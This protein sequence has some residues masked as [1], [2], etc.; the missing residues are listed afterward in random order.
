MAAVLLGLVGIAVQ[1]RAQQRVLG[2]DI[3][4]W[5]CG[6]STNGISQ[7]NWNTAYTTGNRQFVF[8]RATRGGTTGVDQPQGTPGG[9]TTATLSHRYDDPR[10]VQNVNRATSAGMVIGPY[11]FA[12]PD[13]AGNTGT[14]EADH[15]IQM[16]GA[17]MRPGYLMPMFDQEAGSGSDTVAQFAIDFSDRIYAVMQIRPCIYINGNYSSIFQGATQAR[18]D[19]IAKP[20]TY[21]PSVLGPDYPMLWDA[22]YPTNYNE[23]VDNPKDT[24]AGFYGPWDDYGDPNPWSFWQYSSTVSM[25]GF[26]G[27]DST[28]DADVSHGDLEYVRNYLVPA[29]WWND[30][31]GDWGTLANWNSGQTPVAPVTPA[32]QAPPYATEPI[33]TARLPGASGSGPT[34]GQYDTVILERPS[35]NIT[36][37]LS[38]GAYNI[39]KL[40]MRESLNLTGGSLT[41]NYDPTYRPDDST[42]VLH[43]GPISAQFSG[44]VTLS[45]GASFTVHTLQV[46]TTRVFTLAGGTLT[47]NTV[48]L[49]PHASTPAKILM[50]GDAAFNGLAGAT[51][52]ITKGAGSGSS[53]FIDLYGGTRGFNVGDGAN[54]VDLS[55]DVPVTNGGL[56]KTGAG[57]MRVISANTYAGGTTVSAGRLLVNNST[58]SGTGTGGVTVS[59]GTLGGTGTVGGA[60]SL[61]SAGTMAPGTASV[62]GTLKLNSPPALQ[63]TN[64]SRIDRNGG[65]PLADKLVLTSGTLNYGG[66]FVVSN[67]GAALQGGEIFTNFSASSYSGAFAAMSLPALDP[68]FNWYTGGLTNNGTIKVNRKPAAGPLTLTNVVPAL[69]QIPFSTLTANAT[70]PDGDTITVAGVNLIT[71]NG[72]TLTTN[73]TS[74]TYSNRANVTDQLSYTLSDG[75]GGSATGQVTIV[76][77]GSSPSG[78]FVGS[79]AVMGNSI[80]LHF[81]GTPGWTYY[82][83]RSTNLIGWKAIWTNVAP[84]NGLFTYSD[85]FH[86]LSSPAAAAFYRLRW[87]P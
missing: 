41:I 60:V 17:W 5:N 15:F 28:C 48:N 46:D 24:Y 80:S 66:T 7:N 37:T 19:A 71:T 86:D 33:P 32:D 23:Q 75:R 9:G 50:G 4:Y 3:S 59:G 29:I 1:V 45:N 16:A 69:L 84:T 40:Y 51:A 27:V 42:I 2:A 44:P 83:E 52:V 10:F 79:P 68:G 64:R 57:T 65:S 58:G 73:A 54:E 39:R 18:R 36:V 82:L 62:M 63:G 47:F 38:S 53:G 67:G 20:A 21:T 56:A 70:D 30:S 14:D 22:R 25:P 13:V 8:H 87:A 55:L 61:L 11:H 43:G 34:S 49:M 31:D 78:Q 12:R 74:I 35:A 72:I 81:S 76:N 26:N 77:I 6:T 85:D